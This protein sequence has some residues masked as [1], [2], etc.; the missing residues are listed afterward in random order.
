M[1]NHNAVSTHGAYRFR[2]MQ[3]GT[4]NGGFALGGRH[5]GGVAQVN[6]DSNGIAKY[7]LGTFPGPAERT[8]DDALVGN[9]QLSDILAN[10]IQRLPTG[11]SQRTLTAAIIQIDRNLVWDASIGTA[12]AHIHHQATLLQQGYMLRAGGYFSETGAGHP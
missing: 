11:V 12:M 9:I 4:L 3:T 7:P 5:G 6:I 1:G 2:Q 8:A 10:V